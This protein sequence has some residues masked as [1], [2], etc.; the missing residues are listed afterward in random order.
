MRDH[1]SDG[2]AP[3]SLRHRRA[4]PRTL[5]VWGVIATLVLTLAGGAGIAQLAGGFGGQRADARIGD[6]AAS[7]G[8]T[9]AGQSPQFNQASTPMPRTATPDGAS[10]PTSGT[11]QVVVPLTSPSPSATATPGYALTD[12][13]I[14]PERRAKL[15]GHP[16]DHVSVSASSVG[17]PGAATPAATPASSGGDGTDESGFSFDSSTPAA[18]T[19]R[20][21]M[22]RAG[23]PAGPAGQVV[24]LDIEQVVRSTSRCLAYTNFTTLNTMIGNE[25]RGQLL[26]LGEPITADDFTAFSAELPPAVFTVNDV[27]DVQI[28]PDGDATA[29]VQYTVGNQLRQGLWTFTLVPPP[30]SHPGSSEV[31]PAASRW[32]IE[33]ETVQSPDGPADSKTVNVTLDEYSITLDQKNVRNADVTLRIHNKGKQDHEVLLLRL[34]NGAKVE[35]LLT[36]PGPS[37]PDGIS[38]AGQVSV[39]HGQDGVMVLTGLKPGTYALVDLFPDDASGVP[40]L[41]LGM[42]A[43]L[44]IDK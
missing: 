9:G 23:Y 2:A 41:S 15:I 26:G 35:Q 38:V 10:T 22:T 18:G 1:R 37:L 12:A 6:L 28:T 20:G 14:L 43:Q 3:S 33:R 25:F 24:S 5:L 17:T 34:D 39:A 32:Q 42:Q 44:T 8:Q 36:E 40:N 27:S 7:A 21:E 31:L 29:V 19:G 4:T 30:G 13:C 11:P 16:G